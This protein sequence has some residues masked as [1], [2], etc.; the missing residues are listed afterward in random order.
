MGAKLAKTMNLSVRSS[1]RDL[2]G[3]ERTKLP[4]NALVPRE[5]EGKYGLSLWRRRNLE[6]MHTW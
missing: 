1:I 2:K 4:P 3:D 5:E 6:S